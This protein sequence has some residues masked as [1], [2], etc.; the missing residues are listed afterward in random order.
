MCKVVKEGGWVVSAIQGIS[1]AALAEAG[2]NVNFLLRWVQTGGVWAGGH[3]GG[4][5][6]HGA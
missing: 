6:L 5:G 2:L 1:A 4:A 3:G